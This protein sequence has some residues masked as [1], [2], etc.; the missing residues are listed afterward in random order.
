MT[1]FLLPLI[2][3]CFLL[4]GCTGMNS[5][6]D[7]NVTAK[8]R[9][10]TMEEANQKA[11]ASTVR[12]A[13]VQP[14]KSPV[15]VALPK[16]APASVSSVAATGVQA[17]DQHSG[18]TALPATSLRMLTPATPAE[19]GLF[20]PVHSEATGWS[21]I[22]MKAPVRASETIARLWIAGWIDNDDVLHQPSV[23]SFV[24]KPGH[25]VGS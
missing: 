7:C 17:V 1:K 3:G 12:S 10:M 25:W 5:E 16:L 6:F 9:C 4:S 14:G 22:G 15:E 13:A 24:V 11:R 21:D 18:V 2:A 8:D 23:V 20:A 19:T